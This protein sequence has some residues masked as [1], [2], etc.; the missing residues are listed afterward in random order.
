MIILALERSGPRAE[1]RG[2][3][4]GISNPLND[5]FFMKKIIVLLYL[6]FL[7]VGATA[8]QLITHHRFD[9]PDQNALL[10]PPNSI[11]WLGTDELGRD[12]LSR[13]LYGARVSLG[14]ALIATLIS[15]L[16]GLFVGGLAAFKGGLV[17]TALMRLVD[18]FY[19]IPDLLLAILFGVFFGTGFWGLVLSLSAFGWVGI[20]R[21]V[22]GE[23]LRNK[24]ALFVEAGQALGLSQKRLF[25]FHLLPQIK[26]VFFTVLLL[27]IP[28]LILAEST[29]SFV[30]LG[31][32]P[33]Y[34]SWGVL[35]AEGY[36]AMRF[37]PHLI[38]FPSL[39]IFL[40]MLSLKTLKTKRI[41]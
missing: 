11:H 26:S 18:I 10:H 7:T 20:A 22:R 32:K 14:C 12:M 28:A 2:R 9:S 6:V 34:A 4:V 24:T 40:T 19:A 41:S 39:V 17:E 3:R 29:L 36:S 27:K 16:L 21:M 15:G 31:L 30:G 5:R 25:F 23:L 33:P 8:P 38:I 1:S 35:V 13:I 37:Y